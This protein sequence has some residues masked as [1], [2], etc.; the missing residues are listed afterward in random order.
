L[1]KEIMMFSQRQKHEIAEKVQ[2]ILRET[3]H[4]E[5]PK[6]EIFFQLHVA[7]KHPYSWADINNNGFYTLTEPSMVFIL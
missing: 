2:K 3:N 1:G 5:L 7:G 4:P 6:G